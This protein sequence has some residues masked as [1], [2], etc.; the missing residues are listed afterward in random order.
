MTLFREIENE[1]YYIKVLPHTHVADSYETTGRKILKNN[2]PSGGDSN[3]Y[4][5]QKRQLPCPIS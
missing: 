4:C 2:N 1:Q 5:K 3:V